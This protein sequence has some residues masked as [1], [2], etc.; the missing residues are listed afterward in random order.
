LKYYFH[1]I[2]LVIPVLSLCIAASWNNRDDATG[3]W[4]GV[5]AR[6]DKE[7]GLHIDL[8]YTGETFGN[9]SVNNPSYR[10][11]LD[12]ML[13][14]NNKNVRFLHH[15]T[16][17]IYGENGHGSG[18]SDQLG[19]LTPV[20]NL[21]A[22]SFTQLSEFWWLQ[23]LGKIRFRIGKQ[24]A[25]RDFGNPRFTGNFLNSS[26]G[27]LPG[28][29]MPSFP[30][31]GLGG[32]IFFDA[33]KW[34]EIRSGLF[35]G[36]PKIGSFGESAFDNGAGVFT[37]T[38]I[39]LHQA[40]HGKTSGLHQIGF[41]THTGQNRSGIFGVFDLMLASSSKEQSLRSVQFFLRGS[42][43]PQTPTLADEI[44]DY[45]GGGITAH[46]FLGTNNTVGL[47]SGWAKT[48]STQETFIE[49]F[50]K[51]RKIEWLTFEPDAQFYFTHGKHR[52]IFGI[53]SKFKL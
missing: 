21:E 43:S 33:S 18:I 32:V 30:T 37:A 10:G 27:V 38:S 2:L 41:W 42:W 34:L 12:L 9:D 3:D 23:Q 39:V 6:L 4:N 5:R 11:N 14:I 45:A 48:H 53:R 15:A 36:E 28:T 7:Y 13:T 35:E 22:Q 47:G 44:K 17:F 20:S 49:L 19:L 31:P 50:L 16:F 8:D 24:D 25:N 46:G 1:R 40:I 52:F 29:P 26:F 51:L